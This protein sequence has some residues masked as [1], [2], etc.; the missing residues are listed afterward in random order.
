MEEV[1]G[2][3]NYYIWTHKKFDM[4]YN[5]KYIVDV[6]LTSEYKVK[7][8][9][10]IKI[11]FTYEVNWKPSPVKFEDRFDKYLD[12][13]F[14]QHRVS[15]CFFICISFKIS[16]VNKLTISFQFINKTYVSKVKIGK[17]RDFLDYPDFFISWYLRRD[18]FFILKI[19]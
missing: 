10:G 16:Y 13:N 4:G 6:N 1:N 15:S 14:F 19:F 12:P 7:L 5:G 11:P 17:L 3:M 9:L 2:Q 18:R 8:E